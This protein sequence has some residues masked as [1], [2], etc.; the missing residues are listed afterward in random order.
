MPKRVRGMKGRPFTT[1]EFERILDK[2]PEIVGTDTSSSRQYFLKGLSWSGLRLGEALNLHWQ[3]DDSL[4]VD[5][6][7]RRPMMRTRA[8]AEKGNKERLL[9]MAPEFAECLSSKVDEAQGGFV[10]HSQSKR[11]PGERLRP[12]TVSKTVARIGEAA[13]V[14]VADTANGKV[15]M[16]QRPWPTTGV[17][18]PLVD[19]SDAGIAPAANA[20]REHPDDDGVLRRPERRDDGRRGVV[21]RS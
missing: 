18:I 10:F 5:F 21:R 12:D 15:I 14:K 17:R 2:V 11:L 1:E 4:C 16:G 8:E 19:A 13:G 7:G 9:T 6:S 3:N 20:A